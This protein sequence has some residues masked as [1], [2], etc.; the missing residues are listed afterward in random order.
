MPSIF[1]LCCKFTG[2][3]FG[4]KTITSDANRTIHQY[5]QAY[6]R[7][8]SQNRPQPL[9][10][11]SFP[12][13]HSQSYSHQTLMQVRACNSQ[14][15][16]TI[17]RSVIGQRCTQLLSRLITNATWSPSDSSIRYAVSR[18]SSDTSRT[19]SFG[20]FAKKR[21]KILGN[22]TVFI[23]KIG[24]HSSAQVAVFSWW[25]FLNNLSPSI[26]YFK[27]FIIPILAF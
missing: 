23:L 19:N 2:S 21:R 17:C 7:I 25:C 12:V 22:S 15:T 18:G 20:N 26:Y 6:V 10:L 11:F 24:S 13:H 3:I 16:H 5:L 14:T 8:M 1:V 9:H 27:T 4:P